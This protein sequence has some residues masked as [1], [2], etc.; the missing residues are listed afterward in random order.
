VKLGRPQSSFEPYTRR[1]DILT[2]PSLIILLSPPPLPASLS[3]VIWSYIEAHVAADAR[4]RGCAGAK[5]L[6]ASPPHAPDENDIASIGD[7]KGMFVL[8]SGVSTTKSA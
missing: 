8:S 1:R 6:R 4:G 5:E 7:P 3:S 2:F